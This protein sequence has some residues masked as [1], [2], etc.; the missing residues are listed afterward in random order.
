MPNKFAR[1]PRPAVVLVFITFLAGAP[2]AVA[3]EVPPPQTR[4]AAGEPHLV[5]VA[6]FEN[7]SAQPADRWIGAGIAESVAGDLA[8]LE[9]VSVVG[10]EA[11]ALPPQSAIA[12]DVDRRVLERSRELGATW[13]VAGGYQR[14][15]EQLR[16]TARIIDVESGVV[17]ERVA[18]DGDLSDLFAL[19][20]EIVTRLI[21][22]TD[23]GLERL[24]RA[25][26][27]QAPASSRLPAVAGDAGNVV[28]S[29]AA[30]TVSGRAVSSTPGEIDGP[31]APTLPE[32]MSRDEQGGATLRAVRVSEPVRLDGRLDEAVY[33]EV[34]AITGF[35]QQVPDEGAAA[36]EKTEAWIL[37]DDEN[38]YVG[39]RVWDSAP[40]SE[41]V[42]NEMRRDAN[43]LRQNDNFVV[44][45]DTFYDRRNGVAFQT[46]PLGAL[47]DFAITNEG[48]YNGD[49]NPV[50]DVRTGRFPSGWTVEMV[51]PFKSLRYRPGPDQ[52]WGIQLRRGIRRKSEYAYITPLPISAAGGAGGTAG[53]FRISGAATL[54]GLE[55]PD[56]SR[57]L[58]IKPYAI[59]RRTTDLN[60]TPPI[61]GDGDGD[62]GVDVKY[63][64]TRNLTADFTY[65]TD[66]AQVE[67]DEQQAATPSATTS[68]CVGS[69][70][71]AASC[72]WSTAKIGTPIRSCRIG[73]P[74]CGTEASWSRSTGFSVFDEACHG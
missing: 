32:V 7:I 23:A 55:V 14:V 19:Q 11:L 18:L 44:L 36:T 6:L 3:Q 45:F 34:Q 43:Q 26:G 63:G 4:G 35:V 58:E 68:G 65:N 50:W 22:V 29:E 60:A 51:I 17:G 54:V 12:F 56:G 74:S 2:A 28:R 41:W 46:T 59:G 40:P 67:V 33:Q 39:G 27:A 1:A 21:G 72:S 25:L 48:S 37:F 66:F 9:G 49:W 53:I 31:P 64:I 61:L 62:V 5:A 57:N 24:D 42:A 8:R 52:L 30:R 10:R 69:T 47:S 15:G 70:H 71:L 73:S 13:L 38:I 20:D 16:I